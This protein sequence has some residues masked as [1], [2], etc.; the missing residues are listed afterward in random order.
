[1]EAQNKI[2]GK[3]FASQRRLPRLDADTVELEQPKASAQPDVA[4]WRLR[5]RPDVALRETLASLERFV[6]VLTH[7][8]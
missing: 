3:L 8:E 6:S 7:V 4:V 5:N 1:M 2:T